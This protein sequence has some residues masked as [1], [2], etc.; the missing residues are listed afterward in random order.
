M[1]SFGWTY[2]SRDALKKAQAQLANQVQGVRDEIGF[3]ELH[4]RYADRF[5]PGTSVLHTRLRYALFVPWMYEALNKRRI[6][7]SVQRAVERE[8]MRLVKRLEGAGTGVI[9]IT[10][11]DQPA[12]QPPSVV[13]WGALTT[14]GIV[15]PASS[16]A[17][18]TRRELHARLATS[19]RKTDDD[20][21]PLADGVPVFIAL[22]PMREKW[23]E[24]TRLTFQLGAAEAA[25]VRQRWDATPCS[26]DLSRES[27]L[28]RLAR[29]EIGKVDSCWQPPILSLAGP[30]K[31]ALVHAGRC[32][33]LSAVGRA[34]YAALVE[35][36]CVTHDGRPSHLAHH[37]KVLEDVLREHRS[38]AARFD[39]DDVQGDIGPLSPKL[40]AVLTTT[41]T[42]LQQGRSDLAPLADSYTAA[43]IERKRSRARLALTLDG[44]NKRAEWML[45][46]HPAPAPIHYRWSNVRNLLKDLRDAA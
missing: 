1:A 36:L 25:F 15:R 44:R 22:P 46:D 27:L 11:P 38:E 29:A 20:G 5:F 3:L 24:A 14:W 31:Q 17:S 21:V 37:G 12:H 43:E 6:A 42:W 23:D 41:L 19:S 2:L 34:V 30:D 8:E 26:A 10:K 45:D 35:K 40:R 13:Y 33:A 4:Q 39:I 7:G 18:V 9:G 32:A 16:R 28:A